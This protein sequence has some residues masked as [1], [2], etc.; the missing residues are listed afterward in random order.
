MGSCLTPQALLCEN[1]YSCVR[2]GWVV[3]IQNQVNHGL[4]SPGCTPKGAFN[5]FDLTLCMLVHHIK[6][7]MSR[8]EQ[9]MM[10]SLMYKVEQSNSLSHFSIIISSSN[11]E[12]MTTL[13]SKNNS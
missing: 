8:N 4:G 11:S 6:K 13:G 1:Y 3:H 7:P 9:N 12:R 5:E 2:A 10:H